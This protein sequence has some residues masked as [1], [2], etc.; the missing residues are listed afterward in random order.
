MGRI[1]AIDFG[2]KRIGL[3]VTDPNQI[4]ATALDTI[5]SAEI[6]DFLK[7]YFSTESVSKIIIARSSI[8]LPYLIY[9]KKET[10]LYGILQPKNQIIMDYQSVLKDMKKKCFRIQ[11][12]R[13]L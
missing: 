4:I 7:N 10:Y 11:T 9:Y 12:K 1:L 6:L 5:P 2:T 13:I 3:A 8:S